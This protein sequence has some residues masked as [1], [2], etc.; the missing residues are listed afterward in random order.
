MQQHHSHCY[1]AA[2][3]NTHMHSDHTEGLTEL[4]QLRWHFNSQGPYPI[5]GVALSETHYKNAVSSSGFGGTTI[6]G[7]DLVSLALP[8]E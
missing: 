5:P 7:T 1:M 2:I 3:F 6:V 4:M 8:A